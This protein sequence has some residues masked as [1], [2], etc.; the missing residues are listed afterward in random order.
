MRQPA[1]GTCVFFNSRYSN[2]YMTF[3]FKR[4]ALAIAGAGLLALYGCGGGGGDGVASA[5]PVV[6]TLMVSGTAAAGL[7]LV[8]TV[9]VKDSKGVTRST[10]IAANGAYSIDVTDLTAPFLFRAAGTVGGRTYVIHSAASAADTNGTINITPLTDLIVANIAGQLA[11]TYFN[12]GNFSAL[13]KSDLDAETASLKAK[14][15]P[16]LTAMGVDSSIDLL[17]TA[18]TPLSSALDK[19]LDVISVSVDPAT[20]VATITNLVTQQQI[21]DNLATKAAA[22]TTATPLDG[23]GMAT[24]GLPAPATLLPL[25]TSTDPV[26]GTYNFRFGDKSAA[27]FTNQIAANGNVVGGS[28]TNVTIRKIDYVI[29]AS[30]TSPRAF[31]EFDIKNKAGIGLDHVKNMQLVKGTDGVWRLR[32]DGRVLDTYGNA[33]MVKDGLNNCVMTGLEFGFQDLN[34]SNSANVAYVMVSGPGLPVAGLKY[35][36]SQ[37]GDNWTIQNAGNQNGG[38]YYRMASNCNSGNGAAGVSDAAIA[39]IPDD[40]AYTMTG[41]TSADVVAQFSGFDI[42]YKERIQRR[43]M[44]LA[45]AAAATFPSVTTSSP[46]AS[47]TGGA[48]TISATGTDP[49]RYVWFYLGLTDAAFATTSV[50]DDAIPGATGAASA[51][52]TLTTVSPPLTHREIR[53]ESHDIYW[54]NLMTVQNYLN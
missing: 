10:P 41:Y 23:A 46:L 29:T 16:V 19:A 14:L 33:H 26:T 11:E 34:T 9:T 36:R 38:R 4:S 6:Q 45:E 31:V 2:T 53:V 39:A 8:G 28:F 13:T 20:N 15:L 37:T 24:A 3:T 42:Q 48:M 52:L 7:P 54:R 22:E 5:P 49:G 35:Q 44:T 47:Y 27:S 32:G 12:G 40:S 43:P 25:L 30:N 21:T 51:S 1:F 18:F 50:D 17:R